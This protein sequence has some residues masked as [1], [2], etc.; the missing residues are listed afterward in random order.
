MNQDFL[1]LA[2]A[3]VMAWAI[4]VELGCKVTTEFSKS[5]ND[6]A[7]GLADLH[8][9]HADAKQK[10]AASDAALITAADARKNL[11]AKLETHIQKLREQYQL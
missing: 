1:L 7:V 9:T 11:A 5:L 2:G 10:R 8:A 3:C 4:G 6:L